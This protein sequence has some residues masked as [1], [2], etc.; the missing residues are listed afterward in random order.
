MYN[1]W[2]NEFEIKKFFKEKNNVKFPTVKEKLVY[3]SNG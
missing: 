3:F 2:G 1:L